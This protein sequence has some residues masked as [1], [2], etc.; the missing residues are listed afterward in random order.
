MIYRTLHDI[1]IKIYHRIGETKDF[2][3]LEYDS[4][5]E[6]IANSIN[7]TENKKTS[8]KELEKIFDE[9]KAYQF[10]K[11]GVSEEF[12]EVFYITND[13]LKCQIAE[14]EGDETMEPKIKGFETRLAVLFKQFENNNTD[15]ETAHA[16]ERCVVEK[17]TRRDLDKISAFDFYTD[18]K[19]IS[20]R[21]KEMQMDEQI[22][23]LKRA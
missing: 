5:S 15:L 19:D 9:M 10:D 23:K 14:L 6:S 8:L 2:S 16:R 21:F 20:D 22:K 12:K 1:P 13:L 18:L 4:L 7:H 17:E 3:L 11:F